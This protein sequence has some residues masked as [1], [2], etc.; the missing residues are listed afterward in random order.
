LP[1]RLFDLEWHHL[2]HGKKLS[3]VPLTRVE[4]LVPVVFAA[5]YIGLMIITTARG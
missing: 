4:L 2:A 3:Y 1:A 5:I